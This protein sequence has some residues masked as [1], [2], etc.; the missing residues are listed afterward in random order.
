LNA[1]YDIVHTVNAANGLSAD[2]HEFLITPQGTALMTMYQVVEYD[3]SKF[4]GYHPKEDEPLAPTYIWDCIFQEVSIDSGALLYE[5]RA[6]EHINI[7]ST[8]RGIGPGGSRDDA[9]DWFH[10]NSIAKDELGN[11]LI[12][13]RYMHSVIYI[14][15]RTG[16]VIWTLGG[17]END[18]MDLSGGNGT[19]FASQHDARFLP[20]DTFPKM[21]S[22]PEERDGVTTQLLT[23]FDNA[24]EDQ[25]YEYGIA[26][27]RG[28]LLEL[29]YPTEKSSKPVKRTTN[30]PRDP[31]WNEN[32]VHEINGT[33]T[34]YTVRV[35][36]SYE[37]PQRFRSSSQG[38]VQVLLQPLQ[39]TT[40]KSSSVTV[41]TR[42]GPSTPPTA[43]LS[44]MYTTVPQHPGNAATSKAIAHTNFHG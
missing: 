9:F 26:I 32:K 30:D 18:F 17:R 39:T 10:I 33:S 15:G 1:S 4:P 23:L 29:T 8:Y 35:L 5:W 2:L 34:S 7:T 24:A 19:N 16:D 43:R 3:L 38:S 11:Y 40:R 37:N 44:A 14:E 22:P 31:D 27:T 36:Q 12:S 41:S 42:S 13:S 25:H 28:L 21:Y 20:I 6:S